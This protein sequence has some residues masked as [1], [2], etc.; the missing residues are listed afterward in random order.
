[1]GATR[2]ACFLLVTSNR[3]TVTAEAA[4]SSPVVPAILGSGILLTSKCQRLHNFLPGIRSEHYD[5]R[6]PRLF[7]EL[8]LSKRYRFVRNNRECGDQHDRLECCPVSLRSGG[9]LLFKGNHCSVVI[10]SGD[11]GTMGRRANVVIRLIANSTTAASSINAET[12]STFQ[13]H[14]A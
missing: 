11:G 9:S 13:A 6:R 7:Q 12:G 8:Q 5:P 3:V 1:M 10:V 2:A 14:F 4:G